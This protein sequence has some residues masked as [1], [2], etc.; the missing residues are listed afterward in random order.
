MR[1]STNATCKGKDKHTISNAQWQARDLSRAS[2]LRWQYIDGLAIAPGLFDGNRKLTK[3][4]RGSNLIIV[5]VDEHTGDTLAEALASDYVQEYCFAA[6]PS[7][8]YTD[9]KRK[10]HFAFELDETVTALDAYTRLSAHVAA[11]LPMQADKALTRAA[12]GVYGT[13]FTSYEHKKSLSDGLCYLNEKAACVPVLETLRGIARDENISGAGQLTLTSVSVKARTEKHHEQD[14]KAQ[15]RVT[16]DALRY[17]L[18]GWGRRDYEDWLQVCFAAWDGCASLDVM[19]AIIDHPDVMWRPGEKREFPAWWA[20]LKQGK[21]T[22]ASLFY[23]AR[24]NGWLR[25]T[26]ADLQPDDY[27]EIEAYELNDWLS[28]QDV[29]A[30]ALILSPTGSGKTLAAIATLKRLDV[31]KSV[32][33]APSIKLCY[34]LSAKLNA[35]GV[36]NVLYIDDGTTKDAATLQAANVLVTTLQTFAVKVVSKGVDIRDYSLAVID[37]SDELISAFVNL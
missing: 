21:I 1:L 5:D 29:P 22:V 2:F 20:G 28:N 27:H 7:S 9:E 17:A 18:K 10:Y 14:E 13:V 23:R 6:W 33:F 11:Q 37:E 34:D 31:P 3:A 8:S 24:Q 16:L 25:Q 26:S 35:A 30:R 19:Q 15:E 12:Q 36:A 4:W 32:F